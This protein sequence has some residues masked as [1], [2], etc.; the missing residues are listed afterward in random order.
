MWMLYEFL[1][2]LGLLL[3]L[4]S[5]VWRRRLPHRGWSMR[6]GRYPARVAQSL[7]FDSPLDTLGARSGF[8]PAGSSRGAQHS[9][10]IHAVSVGEVLAAQP[11]LRAL[12]QA[13]P[14]H[15]L[16]LSTITPAGFAVASK[17]GEGIPIYFPLDVRGCVGRALDA[18]RPRLLLLVE[19]EL[20]P[21][22]IRATASRGVPIAVVNG[23]LSPR[24]FR[25]HRLVA[26]W[27]RG[28]LERVRLFLMQSQADADRL[29]ALGVSPE[30]VRVVGNVKWDASLGARPT[31][32]AIAEL[33]VR[34]GLTGREEVVVAGS[35]HRGEEAAL[36]RAFLAARSARP[37]A[38]LILAPRHLERLGEVEGAVRGAGLTCARL[39]QAARDWV[40]GLVDTMGQLP[41]YYGLATVAFIGGSLIPHGGQNPL[42]AAS[43]GKPI[44]FGPSMH[45]FDSIIHQ[46]LAHHAARQVTDAGEL[47]RVLEELLADP[48]TSQVMGR[49]AR[50][51]TEQF[52]GA[53]QRTVDALKPLMNKHQ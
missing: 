12:R 14:D 25:R 40:V 41:R 30:K 11:L 23:R 50:E 38:R 8:R 47:T 42:E 4:P 18:L 48:T 37:R 3:Y 9:I 7:S 21:M 52:Q 26:P 46:L 35:T 31:T 2:L 24:A 33:A 6:L 44:V 19:S 49:R 17:Q 36:L 32:E 15:P 34:L 1:Y 22:A 10:W 13:A 27:V 53:T 16:V 28:T 5:A 43:L 39:S 20:W 29:L 45:N 51:L